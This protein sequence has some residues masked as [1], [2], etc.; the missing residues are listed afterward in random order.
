MNTIHYNIFTYLVVVVD[1]K[2]K[3]FFNPLNI[4]KHHIH[5]LFFFAY[6]R[7]DNENMKH[8]IKVRKSEDTS[9]RGQWERCSCL[10]LVL[11]VPGTLELGDAALCRHLDRR[12]VP[13]PDTSQQP[14][15]IRI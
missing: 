15:T 10:I 9:V 4:R 13:V 5:C 7:E 6:C 1:R 14:Y 3:Y 2:H 12:Q 11:F 8:M